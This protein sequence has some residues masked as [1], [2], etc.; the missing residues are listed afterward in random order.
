MG[1]GG[2]IEYKTIGL[3]RPSGGSAR[4]SKSKMILH[5]QEFDTHKVAHNFTHRAL[6]RNKVRLLFKKQVW[7]QQIWIGRRVNLTK[8]KTKLWD[9]FHHSP[10]KKVIFAT[11]TLPC[12][13]WPINWLLRQGP[14]YWLKKAMFFCNL[15]LVQSF[16]HVTSTLRSGQKQFFYVLGT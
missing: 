14:L 2:W 6:H 7:Y 3:R 9:T 11:V 8:T 10:L 16:I 13:R 15:L 4:Q 1:L 5:T 12:P